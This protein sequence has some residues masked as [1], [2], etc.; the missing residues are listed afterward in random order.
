MPL[1]FGKSQASD[2]EKPL[3]NVKKTVIRFTPERHKMVSRYREISHAA[4]DIE[5]KYKRES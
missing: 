4:K 1:I 5:E 3:N 2:Q